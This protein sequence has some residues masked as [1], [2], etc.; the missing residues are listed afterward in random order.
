MVRLAEVGPVRAGF[1]RCAGCCR[2]WLL[3]VGRGAGGRAARAGRSCR[4]DRRSAAC[5][6][7]R[8]LAAWHVGIL[9]TKLANA[10]LFGNFASFLFAI[11][12]FVLLRRLPGRCRRRLLLA[13][14]SGP[15][16]CWAAATSCR[17]VNLVGDLFCLLAGP[18]LHLL[19]IAVDRARRSLAA[20]PTLFIAT[21]AGALPLLLLALATGRDGAADRLVAG[22]PAVGRQPAVR[23]SLLVLLWAI[24][25][26]GDGLGLL[27]Q[28]F[29]AAAIGWVGLRRAAGDACVMGALFVCAGAGADPAAP[30]DGR[31]PLQQ[32]RAGPLIGM[33]SVSPP[34]T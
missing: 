27:T 26:D 21:A 19:L 7:P 18:V 29:A 11:Y 6:S 28:P 14:R 34:S 8:T 10:T 12:G 23:Q 31:G 30:E 16:C 32:H 1:W 25:P 4:A 33:A 5:S 13:G 3:A 9:Q 15:L 17:H 2:C 20:F 24:C 22:H